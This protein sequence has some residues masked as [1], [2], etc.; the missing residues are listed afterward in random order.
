MRML[1]GKT[2]QLDVE[3]SDSIQDV[4]AAIYRQEVI[5]IDLQK[6]TFDRKLLDDCHTLSYYNVVKDSTLWLG[7]RLGGKS[8]PLRF[9]LMTFLT[10]N[11]SVHVLSFK[12]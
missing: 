4:K 3:F 8:A 10:T 2:F 9:M 5:P 12:L 1:T 7:L 6:L 11:N